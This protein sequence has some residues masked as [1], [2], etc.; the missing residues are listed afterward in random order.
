MHMEVGHAARNVYLQTVPPGM[1]TVEAFDD[2]DVEVL[3]EMQD[4]ERVVCIMSI[5]RG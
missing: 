3:L 1:G 2:K 4:D 5:G